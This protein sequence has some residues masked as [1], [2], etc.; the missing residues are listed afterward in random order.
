M[1][2]RGWFGAVHVSA[3]FSDHARMNARSANQGP[4]IDVRRKAQVVSIL[5]DG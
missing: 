5:I 3:E 4:R 2:Q 1:Q